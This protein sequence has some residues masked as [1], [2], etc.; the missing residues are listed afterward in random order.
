MKDLD[1]QRPGPAEPDPSGTPAQQAAEL[2]ID[3]LLRSLGARSEADQSRRL[4]RVVR[5]LHAGE[6]RTP[7]AM[8]EPHASSRRPRARRGWLRVLVLLAVAAGMLVLLSRTGVPGE[9]AALAEVRGAISRMRLPGDRRYEIRV[10]TNTG[11]EVNV[12]PDTID[13]RYPEGFLL[14]RHHPPFSPTDIVVGRDQTGLWSI[15]RSGALNRQNPKRDLP[16]WASLEN[17]W[18]LG[19]TVDQLLEALTGAY[20]LSPG[21]AQTDTIDGGDEH[22]TRITAVR[23]TARRFSPDRVELWIHPATRVVE[24]VELHWDPATAGS[25]KTGRHEGGKRGEGERRGP[26]LRIILQRVDAA[27]LPADWFSPAAHQSPQPASPR[28]S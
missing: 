13:S 2:V 27:A 19:D 17:E 28:R 18:I 26:P 11:A 21:P 12:L 16:P 25:P 7:H 1:D 23:R 9:N 15:G 22:F 5:A 4:D 8:P 10:F 20:D 14:V 3:G 6:T 24:R